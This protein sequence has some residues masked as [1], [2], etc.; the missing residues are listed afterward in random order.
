MKYRNSSSRLISGNPRRRSNS[1]SA[2]IRV[3]TNPSLHQ[4]RPTPTPAAKHQPADR[5]CR[6]R[7]LAPT[8]RLRHIRPIFGECYGHPLTPAKRRQALKMRE[9]GVPV[10]EIAEVLGIGR[11]TLYRHLE[12]T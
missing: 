8:R 3:A 5:A 1:S 11:S 7:K 4:R 6:T 10:G 9:D 2:N 12:S